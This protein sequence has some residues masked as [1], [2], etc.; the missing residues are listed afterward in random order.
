MWRGKWVERICIR[1]DGNKNLGVLCCFMI[2][3]YV[4][5]FTRGY[6]VD[7]LRGFHEEFIDEKPG[8]LEF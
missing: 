4:D 7:D 8:K 5:G 1:S 3:C 2:F 6:E